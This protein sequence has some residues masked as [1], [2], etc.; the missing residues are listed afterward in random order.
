[1]R[2]HQKDNGTALAMNDERLMQRFNGLIKIIVLWNAAILF[3]L[4]V[5]L[6]RKA[7]SASVTRNFCWATFFLEPDFIPAFDSLCIA[8][9]QAS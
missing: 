3:C 2:L 1:M 7:F 8:E 6:S 4:S 5:S 9:I